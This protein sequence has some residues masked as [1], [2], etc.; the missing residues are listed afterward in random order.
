MQNKK[1][2]QYRA[3][4]DHNG[5]TGRGRKTCK[6]YTESDNILVCSW[7][8]YLLPTWNAGSTSLGQQKLGGCCAVALLHWGEPS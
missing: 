8:Q 1:K 7:F 3:V 2:K 4:K 5:E 6:F